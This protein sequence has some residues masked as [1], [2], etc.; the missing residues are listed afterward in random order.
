MHKTISVPEIK[1]TI[2]SSEYKSFVFIKPNRA[3]FFLFQCFDK[4]RHCY[5][6]KNDEYLRQSKQNKL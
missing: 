3:V 2:I 5:K 4:E 6:K 1:M